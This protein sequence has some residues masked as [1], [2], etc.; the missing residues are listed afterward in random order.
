MK[1]AAFFL[2]TNNF[3]PELF[4]REGLN[5]LACSL[6]F[7][8]LSLQILNSLFS[9]SHVCDSAPKCL[10]EAACGEGR[11]TETKGWYHDCAKVDLLLRN[12][13]ASRREI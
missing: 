8:G 9:H 11:G 4:L 10:M 1:D 12:A 3:W 6:L 5:E 7:F 13:S 2:C